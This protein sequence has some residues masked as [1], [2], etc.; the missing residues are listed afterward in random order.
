[1]HS[2]LE[3]KKTNKHQVA[4]KPFCLCDPA[5]LTSRRELA[6]HVQSIQTLRYE[7]CVSNQCLSTGGAIC[8]PVQL[9]VRSVDNNPARASLWIFL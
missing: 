4:P 1:V 9:V 2:S 6:I 5:K 7:Y 8:D 3:F